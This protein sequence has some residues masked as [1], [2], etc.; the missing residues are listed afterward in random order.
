M[1]FTPC[2]LPYALTRK[3][4]TMPF[5]LCP[6]PQSGYYA[7]TTMK[8]LM[9]SKALTAATYHRKLELI[10]AEP[11]IDL[12]AVVPP[13]WI[14]PGVGEYPLEVHQGVGY[15][16]HVLPLRH[17]G[18]H[19]TFS[20]RGLAS[21]LRAEQPD[22][23]HIDEE[24]FNLATYQALRLGVEIGARMC[25]YNWADV[26]RRYPPPFRQ[27]EQ[28]TFKHAHHGLA[29]NHEAAVLLR[30]H[31]WQGPLT[32]VPQFGVD[33]QR[34]TPASTPPPER[35][36]VVG[37]FG[38]LM[39][40]K[41]VLDLLEAL[42]YLP[43]DVHC[44]LIGQ[45]ELSAEVQTQIAQ[46]PLKGRVS[47]EP[48]IPSAAVPDAMRSLHAYVLPSRTTPTWKEQFGRVLIEAM[49][50]EVPVIGSSS[51]EIPHVIGAAGLVFPEG[52]PAALAQAIYR[53]YNDEEYRQQLAHQGRER[54]STLYSQQA[55]A[56]THVAVY[57]QMAAV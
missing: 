47:L 52:N 29:G 41:G 44:R 6:Y 3:A 30:S 38:R 50:C 18:H 7:L 48:L 8:L 13:L 35:P 37:F 21:V 9:L 1:P 55:I 31:G 34:F 45:G 51:G 32:L 42:T 17:N 5:T 49:A 57:R 54:A 16:M 23:L 2:P 10:A 14:E 53:L 26:A 46:T 12:V 22:V 11:D 40:A 20:W 39:R 15:R 56:A 33:L 36:F 4:G 27:F 25:F 43:P 24:A 28:Y 19:H